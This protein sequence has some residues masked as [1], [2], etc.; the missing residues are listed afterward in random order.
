MPARGPPRRHGEQDGQTPT[1]GGLRSPRAGAET[2]TKQPATYRARR[3]L[4]GGKRAGKE[5]KGSGPGGLQLKPRRSE[6]H[7]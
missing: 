6:G 1:S 2:V 4:A 7:V 3:G 5:A